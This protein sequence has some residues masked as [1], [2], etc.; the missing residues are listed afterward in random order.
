MAKDSY[1]FRHDSSAG[2]AF[3]M[4]KMAHI[5]GHWGKGI[6][7]DVIEILRDQADY[8]FDYNDSS[9]QMLADLIGC[10]DETKFITWMRDCVQID[11]F[12]L[13]K[14]RFFS[15]ILC[16]NMGKWEI[17]K[18]NGSE[19]K[20]ETEAKRKHKIREEDIREQNRIEDKINIESELL[21]SSI[22]FESILR[23][24]G[25]KSLEEVKGWVEKY[26]LEMKAKETFAGRGLKDLKSHCVSWIKIELSKKNKGLPKATDSVYIKPIQRDHEAEAKRIMEK[27]NGR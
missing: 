3:R 8:S 15:A 20:S 12:Q 19:P 24:L 5:H 17:K 10:K 25:L 7:W 27:V 6:Y 2:R 13:K 21:T 16:E 4:R 1:W 26:I 23:S 9:L 11:L 18:R 22:W 14:G